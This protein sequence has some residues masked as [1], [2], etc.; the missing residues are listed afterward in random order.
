MMIY[1]WLAF[2]SYAEHGEM[3]QSTLVADAAS[4]VC[5][6]A[7]IGRCEMTCS[8]DDEACGALSR[9]AAPPTAVN[10]SP[11]SAADSAGSL[12]TLAM[13]ILSYNKNDARLAIDNVRQGTR[14]DNGSHFMTHDSRDPSVNWPVTRVT[15]DYSPVTFT[16]WRLRTLGRGKKYR[17]DFDFI[18]CLYA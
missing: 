10:S 14:A 18:L 11:S 9:G 1:H 16:V 17:C 2:V 4:D 12:S 7:S 6:P 13:I 8:G 15:H 5:G 3:L